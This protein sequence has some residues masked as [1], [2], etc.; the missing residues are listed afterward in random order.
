MSSMEQIL[1]KTIIY[2]DDLLYA[3]DFDP[4]AVLRGEKLNEIWRSKEVVQ[5][6]VNKY[7]QF[8][9]F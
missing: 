1:S 6:F 2:I 5:H 7:G 4:L 8:L 9:D 3:Y